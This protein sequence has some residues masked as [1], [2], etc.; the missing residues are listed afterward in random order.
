MWYTR[1]LV[2]LL[3]QLDK[4]KIPKEIDD[5]KNKDGKNNLHMI[6]HSRHAIEAMV[7][8]GVYAYHW[9]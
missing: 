2:E 3:I 5:C 4:K 7:A 6:V 8:V 1:C 9:K